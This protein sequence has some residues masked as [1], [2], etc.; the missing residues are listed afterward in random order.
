MGKSAKMFKVADARPDRKKKNP[1]MMGIDKGSR[2]KE[3]KE[4]ESK[5]DAY[6]KAILSGKSS[7]RK[8]AK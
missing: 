7:K 4:K 1:S 2:K 3:Q 5:R 8:S 6:Q